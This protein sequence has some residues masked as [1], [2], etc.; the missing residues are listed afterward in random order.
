MSR[1]TIN[2]TKRDDSVSSVKI[3]F[4]V[5]R[6]IWNDADH[7]YSDIELMRMRD[8]AYLI[9]EGV[10]KKIKCRK[11]DDDVKLTKADENE[12][13]HTLYPSEYRRAS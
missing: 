10:I 1:K 3:S 6:G 8:F 13:S 12:K 7:Q 4:D 5:M 2:I 11:R 9:I